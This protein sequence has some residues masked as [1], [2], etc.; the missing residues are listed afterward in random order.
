[1]KRTILLFFSLLCLVL[2]FGTNVTHAEQ[3]PENCGQNVGIQA[4]ALVSVPVTEPDVYVRALLAEDHGQATLYFQPL[5]IAGPTTCYK[6]GAIQLGDEWQ[7]VGTI[8]IAARNI[9]GTLVLTLPDTAPGIGSGGPQAILTSSVPPCSLGKAC[10][11]MYQGK[12]FDLAP[13]KISYSADTLI[14]G[15]LTDPANTKVKEIIYSVD[16]VQAYS[17]KQLMPFNMRYVPG[18]EHS[19]ERTVIFTNG[20]TVSDKQVIQHGS[21]GQINYYFTS[22]Y[23]HFSKLII[24]FGSIFGL[25]FIWIC[26]LAVVRALHKRRIW[27]ITHIAGKNS[28]FDATKAG[29]QSPKYFDDSLIDTLRAHK[30]AIGIPLTMIVIVL[31]MYSFVLTSFTVDGVSMETTLH[32]KTVHPLLILPSQLG[33]LTGSGFTPKRGIIVVI[34]KDENNLFTTEVQQ[35]SYVVKRILGLP[36]DRVV[37]Q[38]NTITIFN[39]DNPNGYVPDNMYH[40]T[41]IGT[42]NYFHIDLTL[43]QNE[44]FVVG[45]HREESIDSRFYG[46]ITTSQIIGQVLH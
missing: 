22:L 3:T 24:F 33:K 16:G 20:E 43:K 38:N 2:G 44:V 35:K 13:K 36:N 34:Q 41:N 8:P 29:A 31:A 6:I 18:G 4:N 14:V 46:P 7:K 1:M 28:R 26:I 21:F 15:L 40:W 45:D 37:V 12:P 17:S 10:D 42:N 23:Q 32:D 11:Y 9:P 5:A 27:R 30:K 25:T 39:H 19:L